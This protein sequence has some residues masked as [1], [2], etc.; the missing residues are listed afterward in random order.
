MERSTTEISRRR[1]IVGAADCL[2][3]IEM[4]AAI[5]DREYIIGIVVLNY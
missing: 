1:K 2:V 4:T 3:M 5:F